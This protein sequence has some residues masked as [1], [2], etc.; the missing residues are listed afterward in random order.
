MDNLSSNNLTNNTNTAG[1]DA[2]FPQLKAV[3]VEIIGDD[4]AEFIE[5]T[6]DSAFIGD[7]EMD[8]IQIVKFAEIINE[9]YG[10]EIDFVGWLSKK[11]I[12]QLIDLTIGEVASFIESNQG[13]DQVAKQPVAPDAGV[14]T[15]GSSQ[16][17]TNNETQAGKL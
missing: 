5:I 13:T 12:P 8:S 11:P 10:N 1:Q 16:V 3:I 17:D 6:K 15:Q 7:L 2:V 9:H 4:V 14:D